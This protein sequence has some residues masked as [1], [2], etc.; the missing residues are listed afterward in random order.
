MGVHFSMMV[1]LNLFAGSTPEPEDYDADETLIAKRLQDFFAAEAGYS[2]LQSTKPQTI[3]VALN[4]SPVGLLSWILEKLR[5]WSDCHG[6]VETRF[7]KDDA[8]TMV[9]IYWVTQSYGTSARCYYEAAH[10]PWTPVHTR[11]P[12]VEAPVGISVLP[13]EFITAPRRW[14]ER[15]YNLK[16]KRHHASGGHY[17]AWE[18]PQ[19]IV[20]DVRDFF[21]ALS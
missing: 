14:A 16:Q 15:Y 19:A 12:V 11:M 4:D 7:T 13:E 9:M 17:A 21:R 20:T 5:G 8:L 18:E 1:P 6:E 2:T 3:A 10:H